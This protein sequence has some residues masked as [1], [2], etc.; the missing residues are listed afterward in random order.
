MCANSLKYGVLSTYDQTWFLKREVEGED[1]GRLYISNTITNV[2]TSPTLLRSVAYIINLVFNDHY[3][4]FLKKPT[5]TVDDN[6]EDDKDDEPTPK[7]KDDE[8][9]YKGNLLPKTTNVITRS[10]SQVLGSLNINVDI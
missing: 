7:E 5:V 9:K 2:S 3:A 6:N 8:F 1:Y 4:P 10:K